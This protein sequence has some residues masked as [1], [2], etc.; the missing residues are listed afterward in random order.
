MRG[1]SYLFGN[2]VILDLCRKLDVDLVVRAHQVVQDGYEMSDT[3]MLITIFSAPNYCNGEVRK[4]A[5]Q[6]QIT[7]IQHNLF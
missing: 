4:L 3:Q 7:K 5:S 2:D 1:C 6:S